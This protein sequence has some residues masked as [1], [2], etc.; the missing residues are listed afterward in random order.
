MSEKEDP[1]CLVLKVEVECGGPNAF[2]CDDPDITACV[3][4]ERVGGGCG[5]YII[6]GV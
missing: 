2:V 6:G 3:V 5:V 1:T 4:V